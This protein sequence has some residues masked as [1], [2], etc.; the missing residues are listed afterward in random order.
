MAREAVLYKAAQG[1]QL[2][3]YFLLKAEGKNMPL[4]SS[5]LVA[6]FERTILK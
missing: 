6:Q 2:E 5:E 3:G 1:S 4:I